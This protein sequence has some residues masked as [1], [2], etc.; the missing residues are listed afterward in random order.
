M[1][2]RSLL[3]VLAP[4]ALL[5]GSAQADLNQWITATGQGTPRAFLDL[6]V[7]EAKVV[8]LGPINGDA[9]ATYEF[10]VRGTNAGASS[11]L[12]GAKFTGS[13]DN[14]ALKWEQNPNSLVYGVTEWYVADHYMSNTTFDA[15]VHLAFVV[16][17]VAGTTTLYEDGILVS[18]APYAAWLTGTV[19]LGHWYDGGGSHVDDFDGVLYGVAVY[20]E[21]LPAAE[22][23]DHALAFHSPVGIGGTYCGPAVANSTGS[24]ASIQALGSANLADDLLTLQVTGLPT[25]VFGMCI[26]GL[27]QASTPG[28]A[29]GQ[30]RLCITPPL[31]LLTSEVQSSGSTGTFEIPLHGSA[32]FIPGWGNPGP[33]QTWYFQAWYRDQN[34]AHTT[35][36]SDGYYLQ[37]Q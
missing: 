32:L 16:D 31:A 24:P 27:S 1:K 7:I 4:M 12:M 3:P 13:G 5:C 23:T 19:G 15:D 14:A 34:A 10:C 9:G 8:D 25:N 35:N 28:W 6:M 20:D 17:H 26:G 2:S 29:G 21:A 30:G 37:F 36:L 22:I 11:A 18:D 33:G